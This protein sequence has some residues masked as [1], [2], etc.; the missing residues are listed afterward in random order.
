MKELNRLVFIIIVILLFQSCEMNNTDDDRFYKGKF[1]DEIVIVD[2]SDTL[3]IVI[4]QLESL[5]IAK[6]SILYSY[7]EGNNNSDLITLKLF[8]S[9]GSY[10]Q[11]PKVIKEANIISDTI[12]IWYASREKYNKLLYKNNS[13]TESVTAPKLEYVTIDSILIYK[14]RN[15]IVNLFSRFIK[16]L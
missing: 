13:I 3:N 1:T 8:V 2:E 16:Y 5:P 7:N 14:T 4:E 11:S 6:D 15:K 10:S 12:Y 9:Y